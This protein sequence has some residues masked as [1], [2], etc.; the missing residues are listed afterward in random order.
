MPAFDTV[1]ID[2]FL[3]AYQKHVDDATKK[4]EHLAAKMPKN[5]GVAEMQSSYLLDNIVKALV[6]K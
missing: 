3:V 5:L 6:T 1:K 2:K 4:N